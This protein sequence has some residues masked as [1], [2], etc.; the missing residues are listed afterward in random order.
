MTSTVASTP[1]QSLSMSFDRHIYTE[2]AGYLPSW[3]YTANQDCDPI[4]AL[5]QAHQAQNQSA[6]NIKT[7][8]TGTIQSHHY[9]PTPNM[10]SPAH[11]PHVHLNNHDSHREPL[12][13]HYRHARATRKS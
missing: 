7:L 11:S 8:P 12:S 4:T 9:M 10:H 1:L 13:T 5:L 2:R 6:K 3:F